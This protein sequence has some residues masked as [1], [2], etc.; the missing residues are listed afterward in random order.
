METPRKFKLL[1]RHRTLTRAAIKI[2]QS[3][4]ILC[5]DE[6]E[7]IQKMNGDEYVDI[8]MEELER[9]LKMLRMYPDAF[10][11]LHGDLIRDH[12]LQDI[13]NTTSRV[14]LAMFLYHCA[15]GATYTMVGDRFEKCK[16]V[17]SSCINNVA[18]V[19]CNFGHAM[20]GRL[21]GHG[22]INCVHPEFK[23]APLFQGC[24]GVMDGTHIP[25][26]VH[27]FKERYRDRDN[28]ITVSILIVADMNRRIIFLGTGFVGSLN[29][30]DV[31]RDC[32]QEPN[33]PHPPRGVYCFFVHYSSSSSKF[34]KK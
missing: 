24:Y 15:H 11:K 16:E 14:A 4:T 12:N 31:L 29:D 21:E 19:M 17:V 18:D 1:H 33:F 34:I 32:Q 5:N 7:P 22:D 9:C 28:N 6:H 2:G 13:G 27:E 8:L 25:V 20:V 26:K 10:I 30:A 23:D 3:F